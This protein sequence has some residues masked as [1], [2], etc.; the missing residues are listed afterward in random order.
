MKG[1][2]WHNLLGLPLANQESV[3]EFEILT[4]LRRRGARAG[5]LRRLEPELV[6]DF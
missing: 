2:R 5:R 4:G 1:G 6:T 3:W